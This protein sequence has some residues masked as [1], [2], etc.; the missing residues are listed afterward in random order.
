VVRILIRPRVYNGHISRL[1]HKDKEVTDAAMFGSLNKELPGHKW[2]RGTSDTILEWKEPTII[3]R[4]LAASEL[5]KFLKLLPIL[6]PVFALVGLAKSTGSYVSQV[7][8]T[9]A[10]RLVPIDG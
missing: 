7:D 4:R 9:R 6:F 10:A 5:K 2:Y 8:T 1:W 3:R